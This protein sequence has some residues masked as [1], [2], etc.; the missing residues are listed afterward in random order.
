MELLLPEV[1]AHHRVAVLID[2]IDEL[3]AGHADH[4]SLPS[5]K[6][7]FVEKIPLLDNPPQQ[8]ARTAPVQVSL[9]MGVKKTRGFGRPRKR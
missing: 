8:Y 9:A 6:V 5:L 3:P 1:A 4:A 7:S 2:A